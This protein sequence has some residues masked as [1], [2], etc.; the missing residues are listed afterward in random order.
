MFKKITFHH[1]LMTLLLVHLIIFL[2]VLLM[3][4]NFLY[5][6][7]GF[8]IAKLFNAFGNEIA[9]HRLWCHRS[10]STARWK[11]YLLHFFSIP[12]LYG[13]SITYA[14]I[15]RAHH[16]YA[17]TE[18]DPHITRPWWKVVFYMRNKN[19]QVSPKFVSDLIKDP[20]HK[21]VHRFYFTIN[22]IIL[23]LAI[24]FV[25]IVYVGWF[26]SFMII[27]NF[28]AAGLVNVLGHRPEYGKQVWPTKDKST[29]N[30]LLKWL[31]W[32]EGYHNY[33]HYKPGNYSFVS[34]KGQFDLPG[35]L[36]KHFFKN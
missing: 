24:A 20:V 28:I 32:N 10:Y 34:E 9:L 21:F 29:N 4:W 31:T 25:D 15:H 19:F 18:N 26:L 23:V 7:V 17:D 8:L 5:L 22:T 1:K 3:E 16:A 27:Y 13:S 30:N 36:I 6:I 14:G 33:H 12:L 11:E 35:L 2:Y